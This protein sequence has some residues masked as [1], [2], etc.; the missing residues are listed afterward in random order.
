MR[1]YVATMDLQKGLHAVAFGADDPVEG[2]HVL[3][4][5]VSCP[6]VVSSDQMGKIS[7]SPMIGF[8]DQFNVDLN[9]DM[10]VALSDADSRT[11]ELFFEILTSF[12]L[13]G[14]R[15]ASGLLSS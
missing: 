14:D 2:G 11:S 8:C 10:V 6:C 9:P 13:S 5:T 4:D 15:P 3:D 7:L 12:T 1:V